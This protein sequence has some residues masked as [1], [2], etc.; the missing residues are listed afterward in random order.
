MKKLPVDKRSGVRSVVRITDASFKAMT[1]LPIDVG[2]AC[3]AFNS[4]AV[5]NVTAKRIA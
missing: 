2:K 3:E 1:V 5:R 4:V